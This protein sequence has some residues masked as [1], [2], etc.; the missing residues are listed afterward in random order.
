MDDKAALFREL[1]ENPILASIEPS[2]IL[3]YNEKL[4]QLRREVYQTE[5]NFPHAS[6]GD[7]ADLAIRHQL[8]RKDPQTA[9]PHINRL[10]DKFSE[11]QPIR[12]RSLRCPG[13]SENS[14]WSGRSR[15]CAIWASNAY[16]QNSVTI[17]SRAT[18]KRLARG[19]TSAFLADSLRSNGMG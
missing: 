3:A 6:I 10:G 17:G 1:M 16:S 11:R 2:T 7:L 13:D 18:A 5:R 12:H 19:S 9:N 4:A 14:D 15:P 8:P